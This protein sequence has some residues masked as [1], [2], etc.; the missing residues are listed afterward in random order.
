[1]IDKIKEAKSQLSGD[2]NCQ[3]HEERRVIVVDPIEMRRIVRT[4]C[5]LYPNKLDNLHKTSNFLGRCKF[6]GRC[7]FLKSN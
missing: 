2:T 3:N 6:L 1:M 7:R 5:E 4:Y